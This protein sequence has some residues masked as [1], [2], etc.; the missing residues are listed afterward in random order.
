[1][2]MR[3]QQEHRSRDLALLNLGL[4]SKLRACDLVSLKVRDVGHGE[5][6]HARLQRPGSERP[7]CAARTTCSRAAPIAH[8]TSARAG[9][10]ACCGRGCRTWP[11]LA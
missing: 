10:H 1:M 4:D 6:P 7:A 3:L 2:R 5:H 11:G 8:R 9:T